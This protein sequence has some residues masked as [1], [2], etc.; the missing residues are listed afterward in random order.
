MKVD[1]VKRESTRFGD[2]L[3]GD[4][5]TTIDNETIA[6]IKTENYHSVNAV[7]LNSGVGLHFTPDIRVIPRPEL[8]VVAIN[9]D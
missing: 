9:E 7:V 8:T 3:R 4:T 5:F 6:I 1:M 2:L